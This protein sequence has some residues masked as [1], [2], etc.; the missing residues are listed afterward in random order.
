M[1]GWMVEVLLSRFVKIIA[2]S[3]GCRL[4]RGYYGLEKFY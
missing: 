2:D 4:Y 1:D 3:K